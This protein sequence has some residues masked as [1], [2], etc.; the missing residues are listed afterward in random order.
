MN[1][2][3]IIVEAHQLMR[4]IIKSHGQLCPDNQWLKINQYKLR[5]NNKEH[6]LIIKY[7][8]KN[9]VIEF[10]YWFDNNIYIL[11]I[12]LRLYFSKTALLEAWADS[13]GICHK[14]ITCQ[15]QE[16]KLY[17]DRLIECD[18]LLRQEIEDTNQRFNF[19]PFDINP[20]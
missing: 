6:R 4:N 10:E 12:F 11:K 3:S 14:S 17:L 16:A 7:P 8:M 20:K 19:N 13:N 5:N 1:I 9:Q 15:E 18:V 2:D